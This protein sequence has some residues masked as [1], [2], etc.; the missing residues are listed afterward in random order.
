MARG[1]PPWALALLVAAMLAA[2]APASGA[3]QAQQ[4]QQAGSE[5]QAQP[6]TQADLLA[7]VRGDVAALR[8]SVHG[9]WACHGLDEPRFGGFRGTLSLDGAPTPPEEKGLVQQARHAWAFATYA[10]HGHDEPPRHARC[11]ARG[12]GAGRAEAPVAPAHGGGRHRGG[13]LPSS[14]AMAC[15]AADFMIAHMLDRGTGLFV[16]NVTRDGARVVSPAT[17]LYGQWFAIYA[18][19]QHAAAPFGAREAPELALATF[20][21]LD[22]A[23]HNASTGGWDELPS[24]SFPADAPRRAAARGG[25]APELPRTLNVLLHGT[26]ALVALHRATGDAAVLARL[27]EVV[28]ILC[29][30]LARRRGL[31]LEAYLPA[32]TPGHWAPD[33]AST[34]SYGHNL[35]AAWLLLDTIDHLQAVGALDDAAAMAC[36]DAALAV[37]EAALAAGYDAVHGGVFEAGTPEGGPTSRVKVWW[38]QAE[39]MLALWKLHELRGGSGGHL[40]RLAQTARFVSAHL[41][42]QG[43]AGEMLWQ[44]EADGTSRVWGDADKDSKGNRWKASYHSGRA[45]LFLEAWMRA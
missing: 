19:S 39:S 28:T 33:P 11:D 27:V 8:E 37:G 35:E 10:L 17:V 29:T 5:P 14:A 40:E 42:D 20:T 1:I 9:F 15:S 2:A 44:V 7:Q 34:V 45:A 21:A 24:N 18:L 4:A 22:R 25:A 16:W 32:P 30:R 31:L 41:L 36:R 38:V 26:E 43:G 23:W 13:P 3:A 12:G 6:Q